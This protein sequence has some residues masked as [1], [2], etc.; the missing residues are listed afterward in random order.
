MTEV[1]GAFETKTSPSKLLSRVRKG[2]EVVITHRGKPIARLVPAHEGIDRDI[3]RKAAE[4]I[5]TLAEEIGSRFDWQEWKATETKAD[6]DAGVRSR[7]LGCALLV[8][9][10]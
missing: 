4:N 7:Q 2:E 1:V 3:A 8:P 10:G 6:A 9:F 5:L